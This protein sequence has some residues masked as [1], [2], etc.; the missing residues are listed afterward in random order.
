MASLSSKFHL[1]DFFPPDRSTFFRVQAVGNFLSNARKFSPPKGKITFRL[2]VLEVASSN[3]K[4]S[5]SRGTTPHAAQMPECFLPSSGPEEEGEGE[6]AVVGEGW[7]VTQRDDGSPQWIRLRL[8]VVDEGRGVAPEDQDKLFRPYSQI[9]AGEQQKGGGTG[10]GLCI[11]KVFVEAHCGG[12]IG[13]HSEGASLGSEFFLEF[14]GP[15][16]IEDPS[17]NVSVAQRGKREGGTSKRGR[18]H[19]GTET[20]GTKRE[21]GKKREES[22]RNGRRREDDGNE[23]V[24]ENMAKEE[25]PKTAQ[26]RRRHGKTPKGKEEKGQQ[27]GGDSTL[28]KKGEASLQLPLKPSPGSSPSSFQL[29]AE[30]FIQKF[31]GGGG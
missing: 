11:S 28:A 5:V 17:G 3:L 14:E 30:T 6:G 27:E 23:S 8:S 16:L 25:S 2:E 26:S 21:V 10:L 19:E 31:G 4:K 18:A 13:F 7:E 29:S 9:R 12:K 24:V 15:L 22:A 20:S 1:P